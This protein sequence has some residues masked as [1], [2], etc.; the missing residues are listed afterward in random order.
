MP[1]HVS[2]GINAGPGVRRARP[3]RRRA[4]RARDGRGL[5]ARDRAVR[6]GRRDRLAAQRDVA[7]RT[8]GP[9][10]RSPATRP[11]TTSAARRAPAGME[12]GVR[13][14][15]Y[16]TTDGYIL[17]MASE[18]EFWKNFCEGVGRPELFERWPGSQYGDHARGNTELRA[19]L[20]EIFATR[21]SAEW[22]EFGL[23]HNTPIAPSNTPKTIDDDPQFQDR[24][25]WIPASAGRRRHAADP[26]QVRR[27]DAARCP[28]W[29]RRSASTPSRCCAT[30]SA[31]TTPGSQAAREAGAFGSTALVIKPSD[32]GRHRVISPRHCGGKR[33]VR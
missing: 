22:L 9:S 24:M 14:Q 8:S 2:I 6:R 19:I 10:R 16:A 32:D 28:R 17:F 21:S 3:A 30:C 23:E 18:R 27:R 33:L 20:R 4:A 7:R 11:T 29:R 1:E 5:P 13:Y 31:G 26:D 12:A 15:F 25:P